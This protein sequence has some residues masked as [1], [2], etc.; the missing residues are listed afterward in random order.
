MALVVPNSDEVVVVEEPEE[1]GTLKRK[2]RELE[3]NQKMRQQQLEA[4]W[5]AK[6][7]EDEYWAN[8]ELQAKKID[9]QGYSLTLQAKNELIAQY[10]QERS[11]EER[12]KLQQQEEM[13]EQRRKE[14]EAAEARRQEK[15]RQ[16][17]TSGRSPDKLLVKS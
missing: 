9:E 17:H 7:P 15:L 10:E 4:I 5:D 3:N 14:E 13:E 11:A 6:H 2:L 1:L 8:L 16:F 12:K